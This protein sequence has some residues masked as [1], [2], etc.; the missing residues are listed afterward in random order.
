MPWLIQQVNCWQATWV[1]AY[2]A[3]VSQGGKL[4]SLSNPQQDDTLRNHLI[5]NNYAGIPTLLINVS[6]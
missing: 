1:G 3:C 6:D 4:V 5:V 2:S